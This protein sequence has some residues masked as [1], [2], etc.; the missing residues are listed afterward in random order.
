VNEIRRQLG[1]AANGQP[2]REGTGAAIAALA[3][4]AEQ[5]G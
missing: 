3:G 1:L 5:G 2:Q 4:T